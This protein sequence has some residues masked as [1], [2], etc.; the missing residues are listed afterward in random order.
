MRYGEDLLTKELFAV[1]QIDRRRVP[2][3]NLGLTEV[4]IMM[5][6]CH[7]NIVNTHDIFV[8]KL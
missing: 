5:R 3:K 7:P 1:K 2:T 4:D 6:V 8:S